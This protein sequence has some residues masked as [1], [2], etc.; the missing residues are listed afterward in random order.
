MLH[1][2]IYHNVFVVSTKGL[3]IYNPIL[4]I[5]SEILYSVATRENH[6]FRKYYSGYAGKIGQVFSG[7]G[8]PYLGEN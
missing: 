3:R 7:V 2:K 6:D 1:F 5:T 4:S 8:D